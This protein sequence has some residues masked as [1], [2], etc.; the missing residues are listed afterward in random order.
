MIRANVSR[1]F[2]KIDPYDVSNSQ[3]NLGVDAA[4]ITWQNAIKI[5]NRHADWLLIS[6]DEAVTAM[7]DW[8]QDTGAWDDAEIAAMSSIE[9]LALFVQNIAAELREHL[10]ADDVLLSKSVEIYALTD[11]DD[12]PGSPIG[13]YSL[14]KDDDVYVD[15]YAGV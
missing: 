4:R 3:A 2:D 13:I 7:R 11:W 10:Q 5:A 14:N 8:A 1:M 6:F 9:F 15:Y 12:K